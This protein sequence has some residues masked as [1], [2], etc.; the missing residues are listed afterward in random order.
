M[1]RRPLITCGELCVILVNQDLVRPATLPTC[2]HC[3]RRPTV[4]RE[5]TK[6]N[7]TSRRVISVERL[8][9]QAFLPFGWVS[10]FPSSTGDT[11]FPNS[12]SA[13]QGT[14][15]RFG[16]ISF[17]TST[18]ERSAAPARP[19]ISLFSCSPR[20]SKAYNEGL[21][22]QVLEQHPYTSQTFCPL[23]VGTNADSY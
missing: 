16:D 12:S 6:C 9:R 4:F 21:R 23:G 18:Y 8:S 5:L 19:V 7:M 13:N 11:G 15:L 10:E 20:P 14:A 1:V 17:L 3:E 2:E 22:L